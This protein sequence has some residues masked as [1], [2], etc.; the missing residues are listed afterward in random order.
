MECKDEALFSSISKVIE[1]FASNLRKA[2]KA[3]N[4]NSGSTLHLVT[5]ELMEP[6]PQEI[7]RYIL[8]YVF[9]HEV[10]FHIF[11]EVLRIKTLIFIRDHDDWHKD[12]ETAGEDLT[13]MPKRTSVLAQIGLAYDVC[14]TSRDGRRFLTILTAA[15]A[16]WLLQRR[17]QRRPFVEDLYDETME[18]HPALERNL[19]R[20]ML[21]CVANREH[22]QVEDSQ[23]NRED[24]NIHIVWASDNKAKLIRYVYPGFHDLWHKFNRGTPQGFS[25]EPTMALRRTVSLPSSKELRSKPPPSKDTT[26][27]W[28]PYRNEYPA[29]KDQNNY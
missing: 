18:A 8:Y 14:A 5:Q 27:F 29:V 4:M 13:A 12:G 1:W 6:E 21:Y 17:T 22:E 7:S 15:A 28:T 16:V 20:M 3:R 25:A 11:Q 9:L 19:K 23:D 24:V 26:N 2:S 10:R